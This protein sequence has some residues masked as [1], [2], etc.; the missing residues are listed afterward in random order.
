M[1]IE[2]GP[3]FDPNE[4][5][6]PHNVQAA[7]HT[8]ETVPASPIAKDSGAIDPIARQEAD[9]KTID[10]LRAELGIKV[11]TVNES[12][13]QK[14]ER[15][16][17]L[18]SNYE[19]IQNDPELMAIFDRKMSF[20]FQRE[21]SEALRAH[22]YP[23]RTKVSGLK[24][25]TWKVNLNPKFIKDGFV[26]LL[27]GDHPNLD[28][29]GFYAR[30]YGYGK[31]TTQQLAEQLHS[32]SEV[33]YALYGD[34]RYLTNAQPFSENIAE[35]L[36]HL[37]SAKGGS[38]FISTTTS[39]RCAEAGTG[40]IPDAAEQLQ[41]E[42]YVLK[43]PVDSAIN[44]N[45]GNHFGMEEDE[46]LVPDYVSKEEIVAKFPRGKTEDVYKYLHDLLGVTKE[47]L[48]IQEGSE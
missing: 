18:W 32:S 38:S 19:K 34:E 31:L 16:D 41:Y 14:K 1:G 29:K 35:E 13:E 36:A 20:T 45:T 3:Q 9:A 46:V 26:Y 23:E 11:E 42:I 40:N 10:E 39:I 43:I 7:K 25:D 2:N 33:G 47:D 5:L 8:N 44:S 15:L 4:S 48:R 12:M 17:N 27:R 24:L 30:T 22:G 28:K 21:I 37:Q 6:E